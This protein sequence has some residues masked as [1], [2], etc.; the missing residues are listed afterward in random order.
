MVGEKR[1]FYGDHFV[2]EVF[3]EVKADAFRH[4]VTDFRIVMEKDHIVP[5]SF[6]AW[7]ESLG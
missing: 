6:K 1:S 4:G 7:W 5:P 3:Q 2:H